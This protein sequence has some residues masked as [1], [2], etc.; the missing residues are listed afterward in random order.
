MQTLVQQ[1]QAD[2]EVRQNFAQ[3]ADKIAPGL[4]QRLN[5]FA[6]S[7]TNTMALLQTI[8]ALI[9][10][11]LTGIGIYAA[12]SSAPATV[13]NNTINNYYGPKNEIKIEQI[14]KPKPGKLGSNLTPPKKAR[15]KR[16]KRT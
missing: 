12:L 15:K 16:G 9:T 10:A 6:G 11:L 2:A 4:G 7:H 8:A 14:K 1:G 13:I 3:E 5:A